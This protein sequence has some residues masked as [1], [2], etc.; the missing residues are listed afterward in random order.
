MLQER[1]EVGERRRVVELLPDGLEHGLG[2]LGVHVDLVEA[3]G[4]L[5]LVLNADHLEKV[6]VAAAEKAYCSMQIMTEDFF[7]FCVNCTAG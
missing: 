5:L 1:E 4:Q 3:L 7:I 2:A 6:Q